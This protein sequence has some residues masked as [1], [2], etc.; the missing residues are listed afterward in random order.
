MATISTRKRADGDVSYQVRWVIGGGRGGPGKVWGNET[1]TRLPAAKAFK[2]DVEAAGH[3]WPEGWTKGQGYVTQKQTNGPTLHEV[4]EQ[5]FDYQ[6]RTRI[7][8]NKV[9]ASTVWRYRRI[10]ALHIQ[11]PLGSMLF[12]EIKRAHVDSL[13]HDL[14][15]KFAGKTVRNVHAVLSPIMR[16][17][18]ERL[19][20]RADIPTRGIDLPEL[21]E[22]EKKKVLFFQHG[23]WELFRSHLKSD[24]H[25]LVDVKIT[26]GVRWGELSAIQK[27]HLKRKDDGDIIISIE[28]AWKDRAPDDEDP[29]RHEL[30]ETKTLKIG[31]PKGDKT[32]KVVVTDDVAERLW[33]VAETM[34]DDDFVFQRE[35]DRS[36]G[37]PWR[38][39]DFHYERWTPAREAVEALGFTKKFKPH[40]LR[41]TFVVW[42]LSDGATLEEVSD[43]LGHASIQITYDTYGGMVDPESN[44]LAKRM[45][46]Q[47]KIRSIIPTQHVLEA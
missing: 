5:Y 10:Y 35:G 3:Q 13:I 45:T 17:G 15:K 21:N 42:A 44:A 28:Q 33:I 16:F 38:Y 36:T 14:M 25:L 22:S 31:L 2:A 20:L 6:K 41:H 46:R 39:G 47:R 4:A 26:T 1:F 9:D 18:S 43:Y 30:F 34:D 23:E 37:C 40:M 11:E 29:I 8:M 19:E 32:R 12:A 24:V 7:A 27:R